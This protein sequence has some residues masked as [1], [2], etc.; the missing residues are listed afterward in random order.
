MDIRLPCLTS[1]IKNKE[2]R[3]AMLRSVKKNIAMSKVPNSSPDSGKIEILNHLYIYL[4][5]TSF[6]GLPFYISETVRFRLLITDLDS[7]GNVGFKDY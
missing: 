6:P 3:N 7:A 1:A 2:R 5:L 4:N